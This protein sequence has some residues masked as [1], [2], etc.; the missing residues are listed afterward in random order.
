MFLRLTQSWSFSSRP[1]SIII[2]YLILPLLWLKLFC[3]PLWCRKLN[4]IL[5]V[6]FIVDIVFMKIVCQNGWNCWKL[7]EIVEIGAN[8]PSEMR[9]G[10][11]IVRESRIYKHPWDFYCWYFGIL[12]RVVSWVEC[13]KFFLQYKFINDPRL[14]LVIEIIYNF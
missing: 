11:K 12:R 3:Q 6:E 7:S 13:L 9:D 4:E 2:I 8:S 1:S 14:S 5:S 10:R